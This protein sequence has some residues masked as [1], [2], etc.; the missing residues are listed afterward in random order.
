MTCAARETSTYKLSTIVCS[1]KSVT[2]PSSAMSDLSWTG[3]VP[4]PA[5]F[6]TVLMAPG[7]Q[8][9]MLGCNADKVVDLE[10]AAEVILGICAADLGDCDTSFVQLG[11]DSLA[12]IQFTREV[13]DACG[14]D[15]PVSFVLDH[16]HTLTAIITKVSAPTTI[17]V[18]ASV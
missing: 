12:A 11:G 1:C 8:L 4:C 7:W 18:A 3:Q 2:C 15:M 17:D 5:T 6:S 10:Q 16:S 13:N 9:L 14:V